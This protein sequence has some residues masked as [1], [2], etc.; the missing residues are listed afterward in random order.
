LSSFRGVG[1]VFVPWPTLSG[2]CVLCHGVRGAVICYAAGRWTRYWLRMSLPTGPLPWAAGS[3]YVAQ[4]S[5][6]TTPH[7]PPPA[8]HT[9]RPAPHVPHPSPRTHSHSIS[10]IPHPELSPSHHLCA[11]ARPL[12]ASACSALPHLLG[13]ECPSVRRQSLPQRSR[14]HPHPSPQVRLGP[15]A[16]VDDAQVTRGGGGRPAAA[17]PLRWDAPCTR[18]RLCVCVCACVRACVR[19]CL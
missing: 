6:V 3:R 4:N 2:V 18:K 19:A 16:G 5:T 15:H 11:C 9:S 12:C 7:T 8:P 14:R 17:S 1:L 10:F 13:P